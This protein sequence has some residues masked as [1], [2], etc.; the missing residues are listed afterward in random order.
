MCWHK[1]RSG[2]LLRGHE[3][4][5]KQVY[6]SIAAVT[7]ALG[8]EGIA[9]SRNNQ[10]QG[11]KF[12]GID[13]IYNALNSELAQAELC[14]IPR[15]IDREVVERESARGGA[16]FYVTIKAEYD[17]VA[18][19]DGSCHTASAYGEA[20][21]SGDK[22]TN[23]AMS[24]AYKYMAMQLFCIPTEGDNDAD[25]QTHEVAPAKMSSYSKPAPAPRPVPNMPEIHAEERKQLI[26]RIKAIAPAAKALG[27]LFP[28][29]EPAKMTTAELQGL[30]DICQAATN[31]DP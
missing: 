15:I 16:L 6:K 27:V 5:S 22:A 31:I 29:V 17:I 26:A 21:D 10:G 28:S 30:Y 23:K 18:A 12:R 3:L 25:S 8:K 19:A 2:M 7:R 9:K 20:M 4:E 1:K 24:A 14:I 11:Y 13:D